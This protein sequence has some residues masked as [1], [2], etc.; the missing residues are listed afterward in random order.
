ME[1]QTFFFLFPSLL[2]NLFTQN[3]SWK[4]KAD[5]WNQDSKHIG[6]WF[7]SCVWIQQWFLKFLY[8]T[9]HSPLWTFNSLLLPFNRTRCFVGKKKKK[10]RFL[11]Y[12]CIFVWEDTLKLGEFL[13]L[14]LRCPEI[15]GMAVLGAG[16]HFKRGNCF[17][18]SW[19]SMT[20]G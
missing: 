5:T 20:L 6:L 1:N 15:E 17:C 18:W 4:L 3:L 2:G 16:I 12:L 11:N 10:K 13:L 7:N 8:P 14:E 9:F 19:C